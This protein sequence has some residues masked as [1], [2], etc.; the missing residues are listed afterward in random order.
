M[1]QA[2]K[3]TKI[4]FHRLVMCPSHIVTL[5][6]ECMTQIS[7]DDFTAGTLGRTGH[8]QKRTWLLLFVFGYCQ[9][10]QVA[11]QTLDLRTI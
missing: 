7:L 1:R 5:Q 4:S 8:L 6:K 11:F 2:L 10:R 9:H 3:T